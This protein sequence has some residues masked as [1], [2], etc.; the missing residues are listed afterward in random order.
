MTHT[1]NTSISAGPVIKGAERDKA[2]LKQLPYTLSYNIPIIACI[3]WVYWD[4]IDRQWLLVWCGLMTVIL[5]YRA[6][7]VAIFYRDFLSGIK[8]KWQRV[9]LVGNSAI[10][11][12]MWGWAGILFFIPGQIEYQVFIFIFLIFK[13][14]G[15]ATAVSN[16]FLSFLLYFPISMTPICI[17][18][19]LEDSEASSWLG[20]VGFGA[21]IMLTLLARNL[22]RSLSELIDLRIKN[23]TLLEEALQQKNIADTANTEKTRFLAA[24]SHDLR[25]PLYALSL[26]AG[27][28]EEYKDE[29][30][31]KGITKKIKKS[32][33]SLKTLLDALLN[34]SQLDS[35]TAPL[36][37]QNADL[38]DIFSRLADEFSLIAKEKNLSF[39]WTKK[40]HWIYSD[41]HL[42]EQ[43]LRNLISNALSYTDQGGVTIDTNETEHEIEIS[44]T[45]TGQ[46][47][48]EEHQ[49]K[50]FSEF[51]QVHNYE[52]DRSRGIGLG[53]AI[54]DR[55]IKMLNS[56]ITLTS[57]VGQGSCFTFHLP[58]G[59]AKVSLT[60]S[61][62][63]HSL[64]T[65]L[66]LQVIVIE[67]D[68]EVRDALQ[69]LLT[70]WGCQL[71]LF[72]NG[73]ELIKQ[74]EKTLISA[75]AIISD[76]QLPGKYNGLELV[77]K[78]RRMAK[79]Y[80][81][82]LIITGNLKTD[83]DESVRKEGLLVL[84]KPVSPSKLRAFLQ[85]CLKV[86]IDS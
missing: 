20:I 84:Q 35:G 39:E 3:A 12:L 18:F 14:I 59:S 73:E 79:R 52:R 86:K 37:L 7:A 42:A 60:P 11:G 50:I 30:S 48:E 55:S 6:I 5:I 76:F 9:M 82:A 25:Q 81:S 16:N 28:L 61:N 78:I 24:A 56:N 41:V 85:H 83:L 68:N 33:N 1:D 21:T 80:I 43:I 22:N 69:L 40:T 36:N 46:G 51:Y 71:I 65:Q 34:I 77:L 31:R 13:G 10:S 45:D 8:K 75:D 64:S 23:E 29:E 70:S 58:K 32:V 74:L 54:V 26:L 47:I 17:M 62:T 57:T 38:T 15:S 53:L 72:P 49:A 44:I 4:I 27:A 63:H 19:I 66:N 2:I 67:D